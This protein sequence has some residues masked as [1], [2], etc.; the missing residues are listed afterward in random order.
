VAE[1]GTL[2]GPGDARFHP[3]LP[4][5]DSWC[6]TN[7]FGFIVPEA[8]MRGNAYALFRTNLG[9]CRSMIQVCSSPRRHVLAMDY[10]RDDYHIR[11]PDCDLDAYRL[12]NG[13]EVKM[14]KPMEEWS[15]RFDD[16]RGSR[17]ELV[18]TALMPPVSV[19]E[20]AVP[21]SGAGYA[22]FQRHDPQTPMLTGH[23]D[24][25]MHVQGEVLLDGRVFEVDFP[26]NRDHSWSPRREYGHNIMGNFDEAHFG[27]ERSLLLQTRNDALECGAVT[28]GYLREGREV[29]PWKAGEG[30]YRF[31]GWAITALEYE[32]EDAKGRSHLLRGE[33]VSYSESYHAN[34]YLTTG[35]VRWTLAGEIGWG[36]FKWHWDVQKLQASVR[37]GKFAL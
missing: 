28:H 37:E 24:Q 17:W 32:L 10:L 31:D 3:P 4:G 34:A 6:E 18:Q 8:H 19:T 15:V 35:V 26:S 5:E 12:P 7:W 33:P 25:T 20:I 13:L 36:D 23:I 27:R 11:I 29:I 22:V 14:T 21:D 30:R 9:V 1:I 16:G 2:V